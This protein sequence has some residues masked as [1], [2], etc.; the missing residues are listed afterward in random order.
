MWKVGGKL[1]YRLL[2]ICLLFVFIMILSLLACLIMF[3]INYSDIHAFLIESI[4][5]IT[6]LICLYITNKYKLDKILTIGW[7]FVLVG[8]FMGAI[9]EFETVPKSYMYEIIFENGMY[10]IGMIMLSF[11]FVHVIRNR[12]KL[13]KELDYMAHHDLV[14]GLPNRLFITEKI[15]KVINKKGTVFAV[16]FMDL[17]RFKT[18]NDTLGHK[19]GDLLLQ[20]V[21]ARLIDSIVNM[22][23]LVARQGGDEFLIMVE[24]ACEENAQIV[25]QRIIDAFS[26]P[27][28]LKEHEVYITPSMG[29]SVYPLNGKTVEELIKNADLAMYK[30]KE[31][32]KNTYHMFTPSMKTEI[33]RKKALEDGLRFAIKQEEFRIHYQSKYCLITKQMIGAEAL[34]RWKHPELGEIPPSEFIPIAEETGLIIPIG[35]WVLKQVCKQA[36]EWQRK[37]YLPMVLCVN[38]SARQFLYWDLPKKVEEILREAK[39]DPRYLNLEIT[40]TQAMENATQSIETMKTLKDLGVSIAIDDFGTG[41]TV[42]SYLKNFP[43]DFLKIDQSFIKGALNDPADESIIKAVIDV[44]HSLKL[45]VI[46]EGI[47][48]ERQLELLKGYNCDKGQGYYFS[49]PLAPSEFE[50]I[51]PRAVQGTGIV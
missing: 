34:L 1:N 6:I 50:K 31:K 37:G 11:G 23:D 19:V 42:L 24:G 10:A 17:D 9:E 44:A 14:T 51:M 21:T 20:Q 45:K 29:I 47:E 25:A 28:M 43:I 22:N 15:N 18:I 32:G 41:Y 33:N 38:I 4:P 49:K 7:L 36:V 16:I 35:E 2:M 46:A 30:S 39:L 5:F 13:N 40:E 12:D 48:N 3:H 26:A 8:A 27:F